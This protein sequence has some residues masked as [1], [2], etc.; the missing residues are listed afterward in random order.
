MPVTEFDIFILA[1]LARYYVLTREQIQEILFPGHASGR[2]TRKRL[3]K[4]RQADLIRKH[5]IPV[6][7]P[8]TQGAAPVYY[9]TQQAGNVLAEWFQDE[10]YRAINTRHPRGQAESLDRPERHPPD[11]RSSHCQSV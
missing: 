6:A 9:C 5:R 7:L 10:R 2:S 3:T 11:H 1:L 8:G 4:L